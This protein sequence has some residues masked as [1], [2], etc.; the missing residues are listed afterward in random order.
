MSY[1]EMMTHRKE[2][3]DKADE[4][5]KEYISIA[6]DML[7]KEDNFT[8]YSSVIHKDIESWGVKFE[9]YYDYYDLTSGRGVYTVNA[10][11]ID[12]YIRRNRI[13]RIQQLIKDKKIKT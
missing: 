8:Q 4:L 11:D 12:K 9:Y 5:S 6:Y 13:E 1:K 2:L 3:I 7:L 10:E